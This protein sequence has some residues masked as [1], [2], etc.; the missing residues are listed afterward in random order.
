MRQ[1]QFHKLAEGW[2]TC[3]GPTK[4]GPQPPTPHSARPHGAP[5]SADRPTRRAALSARKRLVNLLTDENSWQ[6]PPRSKSS[7]I[8][9][10]GDGAAGGAGGAGAQAEGA[11]GRAGGA[12]AGVAAAASH[13]A[14][15]DAKGGQQAQGGSDVAA[16]AGSDIE[17]AAAKAAAMMEFMR[18]DTDL[19]DV[20]INIPL[21]EQVDICRGNTALYQPSD[22][23]SGVL[24]C[25]IAKKLFRQDVQYYDKSSKKLCRDS[26]VIPAPYMHWLV[27]GNAPHYTSYPHIYGQDLA[28]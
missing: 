2:N 4:G 20:Y 9:A 18:Q 24:F 1:Y 22:S 13:F 5:M 6:D 23:H 3:E 17:L 19:Y 26:L 8:G 10:G 25:L 16:G 12:T 15:S 28:R 14:N 21:S 27:N 11:A 7:R